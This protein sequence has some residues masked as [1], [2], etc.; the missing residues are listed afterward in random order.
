MMTDIITHSVCNHDTPDRT[1]LCLLK[2]A[3]NVCIHTSSSFIIDA[4]LRLALQLQTLNAAFNLNTAV[5]DHVIALFLGVHRKLSK[6]GQ[7]SANHTVSFQVE[8]NS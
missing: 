6:R 1:R 2:S 3:T 7:T 5:D 8:A 4:S